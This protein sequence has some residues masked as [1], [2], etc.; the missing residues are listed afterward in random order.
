MKTF[1]KTLC[2]LPMLASLHGYAQV[3]KLNSYPAAKAT[4]FLDFDGQYVTGTS[5]NWSGPINAQPA[6]LSND[7]IT[8]IFHRVSEDYRI[9]NLNITTD[10]TIYAAAPINKRTRVIITPTNTWYGNAGGIAYVS[11]FNWG[12]GTPAWVF[13]NLLGNNIK[14]IAEAC[15]HEAGHTLGLQHQSAYNSNCV[16]TAEYS[17]G[18]G[19]GEIGWA[20]IMG[21]GYYKN[22]TTWHNGPSARGC[23]RIQNDI[24][25][26]AGADNDFGFRSDDHGNTHTEATRIGSSGPGFNVSGIVNYSTD[27]DVFQIYLTK[28][29]HLKVTAV[30]ENVGAG[31][32]G[33]D[34]DIEMSLLNASGDTIGRYNPSLLLNAGIDTNLIQGTYYLVAEGVNNTNLQDYGSVGFYSLTGSVSSVP[35]ERFR[36]TGCV[37]NNVHALSW[38]YLT[39]DTISEFEMQVSEDGSSFEKLLQ[40]KPWERNM[41]YTVLSDK[42]LFYRIRA[43]TPDESRYYSNVVSLQP[44]RAGKPVQ[45]INTI[46][47][48]SIGVNSAGQYQYQL[49]T[50]NGQ[51][52][53]QGQLRIGYNSITVKQDVKGMLLMRVYDGRQFWSEKIIS[54]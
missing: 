29:Q 41:N 40:L 18:Q 9:F 52:L 42:K 10:S 39:N 33:A 47:R 54:E 11:S 15:A 26:I 51:L 17:S 27:K 4:I 1:L 23:N 38:S 49:M 35:P 13:S 3:P 14:Y 16:K 50:Q 48:K 6:A 53:Q 2:I 25:I 34:V 37:A 8:E 45:V 32:N 7:A 12:D 24:E 21:V 19:S 36:L 43:V 44:G 46:A 28:A 5:W 22:L 20:P 31:N 30:P